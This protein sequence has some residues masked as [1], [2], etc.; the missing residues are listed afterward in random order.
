[1]LLEV[2][3]NDLKKVIDDVTKTVLENIKEVVFLNVYEDYPYRGDYQRLGDNGGF[4][5]AWS[6]DTAKLLGNVIRAEVGYDWERMDYNPNEHQHGNSVE[7]RRKN[8]AQYIEEGSNY[9]FGGNASEARPFWGVVERMSLDGSVDQMLE[10]AMRSY[11]I[12]FQR[13]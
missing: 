8:L 3:G 4:L 11:G 12:S 10:N 2:V 5:D 9:D 6:R 7:D 1:M 13:I